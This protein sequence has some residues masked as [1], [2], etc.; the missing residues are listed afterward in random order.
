MLKHDYV[1]GKC[2]MKSLTKYKITVEN[3]S[4]LTEVVT[5]RLTAP[6]IIAILVGLVLLGLV[7]AGAIIAFTPLRTLLPGYLK[8][9]Q[10]S[11]TEEG[12]LRLD[13]IMTVYDRNQAYINNILKVTDTDRQPG[14]S[15]AIVPES[16]ELSDDSLMT[17]TVEEQRFVSQMEERERFNISVLAP[18]AAD[19]LLFSPVSAEAIFTAESKTSEEG[20]VVIP[21]DGSIQSAADGSVIAL[22]YSAPDRGFVIVIQ[23]NR[24]FV[25]SYTHTG[26]P[27]VGVGDYVNAGQAI[28]LA[29]SPD[30]KDRRTFIIRMWHNGL[31]IIPYDYLGNS[32]THERQQP[33]PYEA[34][35]GKL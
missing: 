3:E 15:A 24:G 26:T 6:G 13:S 22:Y 12:L 17:A 11:A 25:T 35:R 30:S 7:L 10:R 32:E 14:D 1:Y 27:L 8:E 34:P 28:A 18:L 9:S 33:V 4:H 23:H 20:V 16:R 2:I 19:G 31:P 5:G 29:P 21:R